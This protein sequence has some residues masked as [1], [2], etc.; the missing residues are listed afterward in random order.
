MKTELINLKKNYYTFLDNKARIIRK[1][2]RHHKTG[3]LAGFLG[4]K[5]IKEL[6]KGLREKN[7]NK[8]I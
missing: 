3:S 7:K 5:P 4:K 6:L 8:I 2:V 1:L